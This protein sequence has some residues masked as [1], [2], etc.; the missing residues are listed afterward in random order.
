[1]PSAPLGPIANNHER[2]RESQLTSEDHVPDR[3]EL[4]LLAD[5][6]KKVTE[7]TDTSK[8]CRYDR[9]ISLL[10]PVLIYFF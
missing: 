3:F 7:E 4:F 10:V 1:M 2:R 6:E 5:G 9:S 8:P